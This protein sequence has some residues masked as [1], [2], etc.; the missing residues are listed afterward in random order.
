[1]ENA[2]CKREMA[3]SKGKNLHEAEAYKKWYKRP[4]S[5][6]GAQIAMGAMRKKKSKCSRQCIMIVNEPMPRAA[7]SLV[8]RDRKGKQNEGNRVQ[9][10]HSW[11]KT[12]FSGPPRGGE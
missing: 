3:S 12:H 10:G 1:M 2:K 11:K 7:A 4:L 9:V 6:S 8:Y 5:R